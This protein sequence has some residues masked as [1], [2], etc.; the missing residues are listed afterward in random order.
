MAAPLRQ[1]LQ[2]WDASVSKYVSKKKVCFEKSLRGMI[3]LLTCDNVSSPSRASFVT[4]PFILSRG[5][6]YM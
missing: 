5:L 1:Q 4:N 3:E 2:Q 6:K